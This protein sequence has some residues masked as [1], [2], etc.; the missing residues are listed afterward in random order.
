MTTTGPM[1]GDPKLCDDFWQLRMGQHRWCQ[2]RIG[3]VRAGWWK[4]GETYGWHPEF[5]D[6]TIPL[7]RLAGRPDEAEVLVERL[8]NRTRRRMSSLRQRRCW[9][10]RP[11][12]HWPPNH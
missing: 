8:A 10:G 11:T 9:L 12:T 2:P 5:F 3:E 1:G 6:A 7:L 4:R